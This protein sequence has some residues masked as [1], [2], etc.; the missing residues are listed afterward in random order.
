MH[1]DL[2]HKIVSVFRLLAIFVSIIHYSSYFQVLMKLVDIY[3]DLSE[4]FHKHTTASANGNLL[5]SMI[6]R[7]CPSLRKSK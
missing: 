3:D 7:I 2:L 5:I 1:K 4:C 6:V